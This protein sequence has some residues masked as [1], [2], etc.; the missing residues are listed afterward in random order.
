M[1][2]YDTTK[3]KIQSIRNTLMNLKNVANLRALTPSRKR[4]NNVT[5]ME[6]NIFNA[7]RVSRIERTSTAC[8]SRRH[9]YSL[10]QCNGMPQCRQSRTNCIIPYVFFPRSMWTVAHH[11]KHTTARPHTKENGRRRLSYT[12]WWQ[13]ACWTRTGVLVSTAMHNMCC[14]AWAEH[15]IIRNSRS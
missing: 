9:R 4:L 12:L 2:N 1:K 13:E 8:W 10:T 7:Q 14:Q 11:M 3:T 6:L 15:R 5:C